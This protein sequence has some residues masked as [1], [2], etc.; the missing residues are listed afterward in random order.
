M[1]AKAA[2]LG[3]QGG[4]VVGKGTTGAG[5]GSLLAV[6]AGS[7]QARAVSKV[8]QIAVAGSRPALAAAVA[9]AVGNRPGLAAA[10]GSLQ[11]QA[12]CSLPVQAAGREGYWGYS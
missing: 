9:A 12:A 3:I 10:A 6:V 11:G 4:Q 5:A 8:Q 1:S 2:G 7:L